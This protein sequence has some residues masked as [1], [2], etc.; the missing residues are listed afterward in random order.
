MEEHVIV[1]SS[2]SAI[3]NTPLEQIDVPS[4]CFSLPER[5]FQI[6]EAELAL[7]R[8][9]DDLDGTPGSNGELR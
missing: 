5:G 2:F 8:M 3:I 9:L 4:W 7:A 1:D 6:R